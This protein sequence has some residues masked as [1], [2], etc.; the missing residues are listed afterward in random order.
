[1][2][3]TAKSLIVDLLSTLRGAS[4]PV[5][6][7]IDAGALFGIAEN[8]VRVTLARLYAAGTVARDERGRYRLG[9]RTQA[10]HTRVASYRRMEERLRPW[11]GSWLGCLSPRQRV[12]PGQQERRG[13]ANPSARRAQRFLG[14]RTL[15][16]GLEVRPDNL[17]GGVAAARDQMIA[18]GLAPGARV[19]SLSE[20][21][22]ATDLRA[23][24]LWDASELVASYRA[25]QERI[26]E[27]EARLANLSVDDAMVE[28]FL[29][30]GQVLRQLVLDPLLPEALV[31]RAPR[32]A[33]IQTMVRYD[34]LGRAAWV[35]F[36]QSYDVLPSRAPAD[37]RVDPAAF[38]LAREESR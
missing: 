35:S 24:S 11:Q 25:A 29:V 3:P 32:A 37:L 16:P 23:R 27:S 18:L 34:R 33:L 20:L 21:D 7:L 19:F 22:P 2:K 38:E 31:P 30:G 8:N 6:A 10:V 15:E 5:R 26:T 4:M 1:M 28:S 17:A 9:S 36:L 13:R 12:S 14:L